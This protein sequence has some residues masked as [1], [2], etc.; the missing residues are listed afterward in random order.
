MRASSSLY[1]IAAIAAVA[2]CFS[3]SSSPAIAAEDEHHHDHHIAFLVGNPQEVKDGERVS[4]GMLG[5]AYERRVSERRNFAAAYEHEAF[6]D[7][8][9]RQAI[10][11]VG[12]SYK[13][14]DKR[15]IFAGPGAEGRKPRQ[16]DHFLIRF[17]TGYHFNLGK[18]FSLAPESSVDFV[19]G[20]TRVYVFALAL[21]YGF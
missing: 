15:S 16:H 21:D 12:A 5:V 17:G 1:R 8:T 13:L 3:G 9:Q 19:E 11:F 14:T 18:G 2:G 6:G 20:G 4:G 7:R 10:I